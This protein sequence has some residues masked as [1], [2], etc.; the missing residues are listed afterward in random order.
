[1]ELSRQLSPVVCGEAEVSSALLLILIVMMVRLLCGGGEGRPR[2]RREG[3][4]LVGRWLC[5]GMPAISLS[6]CRAGPMGI[7]TSGAVVGAAA[8]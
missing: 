3:S 4:P 8:A 2:P 1:M 7:H 6:Q 5:R